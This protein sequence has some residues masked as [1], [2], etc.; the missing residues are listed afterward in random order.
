MLI[1]NISCICQL[2]WYTYCKTHNILVICPKNQNV[3][4]LTGVQTVS[5]QHNRSLKAPSLTDCKYYEVYERVSNAI[6]SADESF[7]Q[8]IKLEDTL[9]NHRFDTYEM[10]YVTNHN[11]DGSPKTLQIQPAGTTVCNGIVISKDDF[12][13]GAIIAE[14]ILIHGFVKVHVVRPPQSGKTALSWATKYHLKELARKTK[15]KSLF[16]YICIQK[17]LNE[18]ELDIRKDLLIFGDS[19]EDV[20]IKHLL[21]YRNPTV[22]KIMNDFQNEDNLHLIVFDEIQIAHNHNGNADKLTQA[23]D[24]TWVNRKPVKNDF[25]FDAD[26]FKSIE[27]SS[28]PNCF[29]LTIS[30]TATAPNKLILDRLMANKHPRIIQAYCQP[31]PSYE[32]FQEMLTDGRICNLPAE[33]VV[34]KRPRKT[35]N[36]LLPTVQM[37]ESVIDHYREWFMSDENTIAVQRI[38]YK[39]NEFPFLRNLLTPLFDVDSDKWVPL[40]KRKNFKVI[41]LNGD[42]DLSHGA[43]SC[44]EFMPDNQYHWRKYEG[45]IEIANNIIPRYNFHLS[46]RDKLFNYE[47]NGKTLILVCQGLTVGERIAVKKHIGLWV[48]IGSNPNFLLQSIGRLFGYPTNESKKFTGKI[49]VNMNSTKQY[50]IAL[51]GFY[52]FYENIKSFGVSSFFPNSGYLTES[53]M[54]RRAYSK[55]KVTRNPSDINAQR[56]VSDVIHNNLTSQVRKMRDNYGHDMTQQEKGD[57]VAKQKAFYYPRFDIKDDVFLLKEGLDFKGFQRLSHT[58]GTSDYNDPDKRIHPRDKSNFWH[59]YGLMQQA[60]RMDLVDMNKSNALSGE[61]MPQQYVNKQIAVITKPSDIC[62]KCEPGKCENMESGKEPCEP[63][64]KKF[65]DAYDA[66]RQSLEEPPISPENPVFIEIEKDYKSVFSPAQFTKESTFQE[67]DHFTE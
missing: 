15:K 50:Q 66:Y 51:D 67:E 28:S 14:T 60:G 56:V 65:F 5:N 29:I 16:T 36:S 9:G 54:K 40:E 30:A 25:D 7:L 35:G 1:E 55:L 6:S 32:G 13:R 11:L 33:S 39:E 17:G 59:D 61:P 49:L 21:N 45:E 57:F 42:K 62:G 23:V 34:F 48:E 43:I 37:N 3:F 10:K 58:I 2:V 63:W 46:F 8:H 24:N 64:D 47:P 53:G 38:N 18:L 31:N 20:T 26:T 52:D 4:T 41:L 27:N 12:V 44:N 22:S 19:T